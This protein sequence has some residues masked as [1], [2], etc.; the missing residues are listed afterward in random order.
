M[1]TLTKKEK[2]ELK[3]SSKVFMTH[4]QCLMSEIFRRGKYDEWKN[5]KYSPREDST[6]PK[7]FT[8]EK[9]T[10]ETARLA[11]E[12]HLKRETEFPQKEKVL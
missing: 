11:W 8:V 7:V 9:M 10:P 2:E 1:S 6:F 4:Y 12:Y 5:N 3:L